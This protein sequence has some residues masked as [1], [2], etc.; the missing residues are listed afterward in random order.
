MRKSP[1]SVNMIFAVLKTLNIKRLF[2]LR[3]HLKSFGD[4]VLPISGYI[5]L[6]GSF[7]S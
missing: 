2:F 6:V 7:V 1:Y 4:T 3:M 5:L